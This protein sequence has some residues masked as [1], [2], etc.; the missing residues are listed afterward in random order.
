MNPQAQQ[1]QNLTQKMHHYLQSQVQRNLLQQ[2][3]LEQQ[4]QQQVIP[5]QEQIQLQQSREAQIQSPVVTSLQ[6]PQSEA[7]YQ[8][9]VQVY[10]QVQFAKGIH[11]QAQIQ[12]FATKPLLR[13][14]STPTKNFNL[15]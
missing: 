2:P 1:Q 5:A 7:S 12:T 8:L 13:S 15:Y 6:Y 4:Q 3:E 10:G 14:K 11:D 9:P